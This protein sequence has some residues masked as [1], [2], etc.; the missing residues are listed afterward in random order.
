MIVSA[1][2]SKYVKAYRAVMNALM[3]GLG[4][5]IAIKL[6]Q[7]E[8]PWLSLPIVSDIYSNIVHFVAA[9]FS[10]GLERLG[11]KVILDIEKSGRLK[12]FEDAKKYISDN[13]HMSPAQLKSASDAAYRIIY[14]YRD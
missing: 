9:E 6:G 3:T 14:K 13:K 12:E 10:L 1:P 11:A 7:A 8:W 4:A 5:E 2:A